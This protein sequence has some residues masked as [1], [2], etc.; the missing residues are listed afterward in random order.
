MPDICAIWQH[1]RI[2]RHEH[3]TG[4]VISNLLAGI[5]ACVVVAHVAGSLR[6]L[7]TMAVIVAYSYW[8]F[9]VPLSLLAHLGAAMQ[10]IVPDLG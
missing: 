5:I 8:V 3:G 2:G 6:Y 4:A 9:H 10:A 7:S 1:A